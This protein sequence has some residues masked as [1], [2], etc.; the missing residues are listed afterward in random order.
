M[1]KKKDMAELLNGLE[2][3]SAIDHEAKVARTVERAGS[4][5]SRKPSNDKRDPGND[6]RRA[7]A[8]VSMTASEKKRLTAVAKAHGLSLSAF[9]RLAAGEYIKEH[10]WAVE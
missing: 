10:D 2:A 4:E 8:L 6:T 9:L 7:T 3:S 5:A 1:V